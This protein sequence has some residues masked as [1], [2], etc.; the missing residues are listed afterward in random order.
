MGGAEIFPSLVYVC[1]NN[2]E[3]WLKNFNCNDN[4]KTVK[5]TNGL[6]QERLQNKRHNFPS[7]WKS[8]LTT[9]ENN[10]FVIAGFTTRS[11]EKREADI[12]SSKYV[13]ANQVGTKVAS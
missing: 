7:I 2:N 8:K 11:A 5:S 6:N 1:I 9:W 4:W 10:L 3:A 13:L 12:S